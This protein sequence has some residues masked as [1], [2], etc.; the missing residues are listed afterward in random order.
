MNQHPYIRY[1][2]ALICVENN[3]SENSKIEDINPKFLLNEIENG[4]N[5]FRVKAKS[6]KG[7]EE[8]G[9]EYV[10]LEK[11]D[12]NNGIFLS[13]NIICTDKAAGNFYKAC[14]KNVE[15]L[16]R[17]VEDV[18][19][20]LSKQD[21]ASMSSMPTSSEFLGFSTNGG[22]SRNSPKVTNYENVL[23]LITG[24]TNLKPFIVT[25][26]YSKKRNEYR[27]TTIIPDLDIGNLMNF[28]KL[29]KG[30][31][32]KKVEGLMKGRVFKELDKKG[33]IKNEKPMRPYLFNG[34]FPNAPRSTS[35]GA[36]A[37]LG[38]LG[39]IAKD[40]EFHEIGTKVLDSLKEA[41]M[42]MIQYGSVNT[43]RFNHHIVELAK[44]NKL[45]T[46]IDSA[47]YSVL[48]REGSRNANNREEYQK[49]DLF[50]SRFLMLFNTSTFRD[51]LAFRA[52][53]SPNLKELL[54]T[55]FTKMENENLKIVQSARKFGQWLNLAAFLT[56]KNDVGT[57]QQKINEVKAKVLVEL[58][59]AAFSA[60]TTDALF[61]QLMTRVGRLSGLDAPE[62]ATEFMEA[63]LS[64]AVTLEKAKNMVIAFM[65]LRNKKETKEN[66]AFDI[67]EDD[68]N[69]I[70]T[71]DD[72]SE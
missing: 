14:K 64:G 67:D 41:Q 36:I 63:T 40:V 29:F 45:K 20:Y 23:G 54:I 52:E 55:Y 21:D 65:R 49:F 1:A 59:S 31:Q 11:G 47:Y 33:V 3:L 70:E 32:L 66:S 34:N 24:C 53:Y 72:A 16:N 17:K 25:K 28:I 61:A 56:A 48:L 69:D 60:K 58:E 22:I 9:F 46:I 35:L 44:K 8:V 51:F 27:N 68:I 26:T 7:M 62:G 71:S 43:F 2:H 12:T 10:N 4:L 6:F 38:A 30:I 13:G 5:H 39:E 42:Y 19:K 18:I 57:N 15:T 37:L 50:L